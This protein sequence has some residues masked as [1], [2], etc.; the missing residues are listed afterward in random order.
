VAAVALAAGLVVVVGGA[1]QAQADSTISYSGTTSGTASTIVLHSGDSFERTINPAGSVLATINDTTGNLVSASTTFAPAYSDNFAGPFN[2]W[3][4]VGTLLEQQGGATG[5]IT[6]TATEGVQ[7]I[8]VAVTNRL[9]VTVY[10]VATETT[11]H[12]PATDQKITLPER[13]WT[14]ISMNL[15]GTVNRRTGDLS[16]AQD[17]FTIPPFPGD[18]GDTTNPPDPTDTNHRCQ[19]A[20]TSLN[21]QL[22]GTNN[23]VE[24]NFSG[25]PTTAHVEATAQAPDS[26]LSITPRA[27]LPKA[28]FVVGGTATADLDFTAGTMSNISLDLDPIDETTPVDYTPNATGRATF[29]LMSPTGSLSDSGTIGVDNASLSGTLRMHTSVWAG[30]T[31]NPGTLLADGATCYVDIAF[32]ATGTLDRG[33]NLLKLDSTFTVPEFSPGASVSEGCWQQAVGLSNHLS[34]GGNTMSLVLLAG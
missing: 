8:T 29:E 10:K 1:P 25:G 12:N 9:R 34:G 23:S 4:Y 5:T 32:T 7:D 14:D 33:T 27:D 21:Q 13:C 3:F 2:T 18:P 30:P 11:A 22:A 19:Q 20:T 28:D 15:A 16:L 17:P 26:Q 24:L 31:Q 6:P